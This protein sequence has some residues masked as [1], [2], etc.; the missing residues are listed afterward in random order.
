MQS[1]LKIGISAKF[2]DKAPTFY[3]VAPRHIQYLETP[4][5]KW[6]AGKKALPLMIPSESSVSDIGEKSLDAQGYAR[7][8]DALI[9]QGG[10]DLHPETTGVPLPSNAKYPVDRV[11]D[12]YELALIE[13]FI[14]EGKPI[15]GICRGL[16]L[17][18]VF[19][20]GS[21]HSDLQEDG[22]SKHFDQDLE[23]EYTHEICVEENGILSSIYPENAKVVSLHHQGILRLGEGLMVE[24]T[25]PSDKLIEAFSCIQPDKYILAVQWHPEFHDAKSETL[26]GGK[27]LELFLNTARNRKF[28]GTLSAKR[29]NRIHLTK[30]SLL[31]LGTELELQVIDP[32]N[33][34]LTP[35]APEIISEC[36]KLTHKVKSEI[37]QSMIEIETDICTNANEI[38]D[39]LA[40]TLKILKPILDQ[41]NLLLGSTGT[42]PFARYSERILTPDDRYS[43]LIE[44]KQW[45]ARRISIFGLHCHVGVQNPSQAIELYRFYLSIAPLL[46]ALSTSSP[47][48]QSENTGLHSVRSTFF[49]SMPS[50]GHPPILTSWIEFEGLMSKMIQSRSIQSYKD[51]WW[52]IRPS[53]NY[54]TVEVRICDS[55]PT[56]EE[57]VSL[58]SLIHLLG[59]AYIHHPKYEFWPHLSDWSY[60]ENKWRALRYGTDFNFIFNDRGN[61]RP[62]W[63]IL[64][65][66]LADFQSIVSELQYDSLIEK[67]LAR[68]NRASASQR[69][70][71][72]FHQ[73]KDLKN[74]VRN[75]CEELFLNI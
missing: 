11:R 33:F 57:N 46:L 6:I 17:I 60:R 25:C 35:F 27:L 64:E 73:S 30:S 40:E 74:V 75:Y 45:I 34:D 28:F 67:L 16:Q 37:F 23:T 36:K 50:G 41:K 18:N 20:G 47:F 71:N 68:K 43:N 31:T 61:S 72:E 7:E 58:I 14:A 59:Y 19:F 32:V 48:F 15:L 38:R 65:Q 13:A 2:H 21:L 55:L 69:Q 51:L 42:H 24:A 52:D 63:E 56:L 10:V 26:P 44:S 22:L 4:V 54:G 53:L 62:C 66:Y 12:L 49:E 29:R 39:D 5:A 3:G 1:N 9:L 70:I 8:L